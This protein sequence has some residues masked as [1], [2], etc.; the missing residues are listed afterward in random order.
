[1]KIEIWEQCHLLWQYRTYILLQANLASPQ[2][3]KSSGSGVASSMYVCVWWWS[4]LL[5]FTSTAAGSFPKWCHT[6]QSFWYILDVLFHYIITFV[7]VR[8]VVVFWRQ[9]L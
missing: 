7:K 4:L 3:P 9:T 1:M 2:V 5:H 8:V 6:L